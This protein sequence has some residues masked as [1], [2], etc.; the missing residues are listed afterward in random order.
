VVKT[1]FRPSTK[2]WFA[3]LRQWTKFEP[4]NYG[5]IPILTACLFIIVCA[6]F[7]SRVLIKLLRFINRYN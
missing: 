4:V 2:A 1:I 5:Y 7:A 3:R 6:F